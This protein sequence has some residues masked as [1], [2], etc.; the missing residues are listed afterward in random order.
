MLNYFRASRAR[1]RANYLRGGGGRGEY[2]PGKFSIIVNELFKGGGIEC[3]KAHCEKAPVIFV[4][5]LTMMFKNN[6]LS[7][8]KPINIR[9]TRTGSQTI[10]KSCI[11]TNYRQFF[12]NIKIKI[13]ILI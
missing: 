7:S 10:K 13:L 3:L 6:N 11:A 2:I 5:Q 4:V 12:P 8:S 9:W 1:A